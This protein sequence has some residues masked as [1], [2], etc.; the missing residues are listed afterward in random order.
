MTA[1]KAINREDARRRGVQGRGGVARWNALSSNRFT[2]YSSKYMRL[3]PA[4]TSEPQHEI[5]H[6]SARFVGKTY[7]GMHRLIG[8]PDTTTL[9]QSKLK[10][11]AADS[12][13]ADLA[14]A[15]RRRL[16]RA[17]ASCS[18]PAREGV[19]NQGSA[20]WGGTLPLV[21]PCTHGS[22]QVATLVTPWNP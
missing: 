5:A 8:S 6:L 9:F 15:I 4:Q 17:A 12:K 21:T 19:A 22:P 7:C 1:M 11:G 13:S 10:L 18:A 2:K 16:A 14:S 3:R 20:P